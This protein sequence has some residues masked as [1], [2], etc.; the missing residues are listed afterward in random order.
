[1]RRIPWPTTHAGL[2]PDDIPYD[3]SA[4]QTIWDDDSGYG[5]KVVGSEIDDAGRTVI[6]VALSPGRYLPV[7]LVSAGPAPEE[8]VRGFLEA[9]TLVRDS[10]VE[11]V[12]Q[13]PQRPDWAPDQGQET[14]EAV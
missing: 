13:T 12:P 14:R 8:Q 3:Y 9:L 11:P 10:P 6:T 2:T 4:F 5:P 7:T 1:M